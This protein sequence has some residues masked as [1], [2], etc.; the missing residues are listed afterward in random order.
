MTDQNTFIPSHKSSSMA[1]RTVLVVWLVAVAIAFWWFQFRYLGNYRD[2]YVSFTGESL[3]QPLPEHLRGAIRIA[4]ILDPNC[5]CARFSH[6]HITDMEEA[7]AGK[8]NFSRWQDLPS[9]FVKNVEIPASPAVAVW[10]SRGDLA[11]FGPYSGGAFC[12]EGEDFVDS[13]INMIRQNENP[14]WINHDALGYF[15]VLI[16]LKIQVPNLLFINR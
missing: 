7:Y 5:P 13:V 6:Q 11:Y 14:R 16:L 2:F 12:G 9:N 1:A 3:S 15:F 8:V 4:H 10:D